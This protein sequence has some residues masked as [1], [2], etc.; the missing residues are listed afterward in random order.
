M[1][2]WPR[3]NWLICYATTTGRLAQWPPSNTTWLICFATTTGRLAQW[4]PSN[5]TWL[6]WF[7]T[8]TGQFDQTWRTVQNK[9]RSGWYTGSRSG[10]H[11]P[12][13]LINYTY[14]TFQQ[15]N[16]ITYRPNSNKRAIKL[17]P[18]PTNN[19]VLERPTNCDARGSILCATKLWR[20]SKWRWKDERP[21]DRT[22]KHGSAFACVHRTTTR[23]QVAQEIR[24]RSCFV[25][26]NK[27][28]VV[29]LPTR[30]YGFLPEAH[31]V[32]NDTRQNRSNSRLILK[33]WGV[34]N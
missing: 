13:A 9:P 19:H 18:S 25:E 21:A 12:Q 17:E 3:S 24:K 30:S 1:A 20:H 22:K 26:R 15:H 8:A 4:P 23:S 5:T 14:E 28:Q 10:T 7:A 11:F 27:I 33:K 34:L 29:W 16:K 6:I 31:I 32:M 2:Q